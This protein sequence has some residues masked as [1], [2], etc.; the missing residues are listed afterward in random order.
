VGTRRSHKVHGV[1]C[2]WIEVHQEGKINSEACVAKLSDTNLN[3][4][5]YQTLHGFFNAIENVVNEFGATQ[6]D[7]QINNL[8]FDNNRVPLKLKDNKHISGKEV[9]LE[10][11]LGS[12]DASL[13]TVPK[14]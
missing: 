11:I 12:F 2:S 9:S 1:R 4:K 5:D 14:E 13:F 3:E 10:F 7:M 6:Q 8:M